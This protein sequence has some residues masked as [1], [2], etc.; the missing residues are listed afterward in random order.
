MLIQSRVLL[1]KTKKYVNDSE[2][3][4]HKR[5]KKLNIIINVCS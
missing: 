3:Y 2:S 5:K 1:D 4:L